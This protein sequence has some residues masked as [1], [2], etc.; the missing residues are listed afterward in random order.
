YER[1]SQKVFLQQ[2]GPGAIVFDVGANVG[3]FTLLAS[4]LAGPGGHVY[5]FEPVPLNLEFLRRHLQLNKSGNV[6]VL[7][8][9]ASSTRG[10]AHFALAGSPSMGSLS[11][12]GELTVRTETLDALIAAGTARP[13]TFM[14]IDVEGAEYDVLTGAAETLRQYEPAIFL[15]THGYLQHERCWA[16][17]EGSGY[18]PELLRDGVADGN[19]LV[20]ATPKRKAATS[21]SLS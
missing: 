11:A 5:A 19:Y 2:V 20:L 7:P 12:D 17:L 8:L 13:P 14:K 6:T 9:A 4:R 15:S 16:L 1:E 3:F 10:T 21:T 18:A